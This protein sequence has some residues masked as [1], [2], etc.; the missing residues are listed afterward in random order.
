[1]NGHR[2]M[3]SATAAGLALTCLIWSPSSH[4]QGT[5][6]VTSPLGPSGGPVV[7][8]TTSEYNG[9]NRAVIASGLTIFGLSYIPA[10]IVASESSLGVDRNLYAPVAGPWI[11][12]ANRPGCPPGSAPCGTETANK[13]LIGIDG[14]FQ[15]IGALT[16]LI[17]LV[18]P[19]HHKVLVAA[20]N[21]KPTVRVT[22]VQFSSGSYGMAAY[23]RF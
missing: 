9:P 6:V 1:M 8:E 22:P 4:A 5:T 7:A 19:E 14:A 17:G 23:G 3:A 18:V 15:G 16:T 10:V 20:K 2:I 21:D 13:V 12:L 11:N